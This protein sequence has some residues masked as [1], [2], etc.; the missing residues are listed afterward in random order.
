MGAD[1]LLA[2][3]HKPEAEKPFVE[4]DFRAFEYRA[5]RDREGFA[6][7]I[8]HD[9]AGAGAVAL[10]AGNA[11]GFATMRA[12]GTVRPMKAFKVLT[13]F[14]GVGINRI[15]EVECH[16]DF[17]HHLGCYAKYITAR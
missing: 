1:A 10:K 9:D 2:G 15:S 8:A 4:R 14:V 3:R 5:N 13:G 6:A 16:A 11:L 7:G 12:H 17:I